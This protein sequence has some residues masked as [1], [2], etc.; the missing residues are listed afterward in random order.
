MFCIRLKLHG[1][2]SLLKTLQQDNLQKT[3]RSCYQRKTGTETLHKTLIAINFLPTSYIEYLLHRLKE[4][5]SFLRVHSWMLS[6]KQQHRKSAWNDELT[7]KRRRHGHAV[8]QSLDVI[9]MSTPP[10]QRSPRKRRQRRTSGNTYSRVS[11]GATEASLS[12]PETLTLIRVRV[13]VRVSVEYVKQTTTK[14]EH[15]L[16]H[17]CIISWWEMWICEL[18]GAIPFIF[19]KSRLE[20]CHVWFLYSPNPKWKGVLLVSL[21]NPN[22]ELPMGGSQMSHCQWIWSQVWNPHKSL[23]P[24]RKNLGDERLGCHKTCIEERHGCH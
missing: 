9:T 5:N 10:R 4:A 13:R 3:K 8:D 12:A 1:L 14:E 19:L 17:C 11:F 18:V 15:V 2:N 23:S 7:C 21:N 6:T 20:S 24:K 22:T 16:K